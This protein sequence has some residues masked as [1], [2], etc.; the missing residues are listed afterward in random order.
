MVTHFRAQVQMKGSAQVKVTKTDYI[1]L[2]ADTANLNYLLNGSSPLYIL[3][4]AQT[5][6]FWYLWA[7]EENSRRFRENPAWPQQT[8]ITLDVRTSSRV[9]A[10]F[11]GRNAAVNDHVEAGR[12]RFH[13]AE[14]LGCN[15]AQL[16]VGLAR[17]F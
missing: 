12:R 8:S 15:P 1:P 6:Q 16:L 9:L 3:W 17:M 14:H 4:D 11:A 5:N 13:G 2:R 10:I 7:Q